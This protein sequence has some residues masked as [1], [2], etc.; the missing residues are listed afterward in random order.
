[1]S[2]SINQAFSNTKKGNKNDELYTP[3][4]LVDAVYPIF[5]E[6]LEA[7]RYDKHRTPVVLCPFD[8]ETSEFVIK[9]SE[10]YDVKFG[11]ISTGED[12]FTHDYGKWD[13]CISN[14]PFSRKLDVFKKLDSFR[15]PWAMICNVMALNYHVVINYFTDNPKELIFFDKRVS[16]N[17]NP[18]S[19]GS[20]F[21]CNDMMLTEVK[22]LK[23]P[24]N[25][26]GKNFIPSRMLIGN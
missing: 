12:F 4:L 21:V 22:Y 17:G 15:S 13:A 25:N 10:K 19:F 26:V 24:H 2:H 20:C 16:F 6:R 14:P 5:S 1:M 7:I 9:F 3:K 23:L 8:L 18:S 11:H